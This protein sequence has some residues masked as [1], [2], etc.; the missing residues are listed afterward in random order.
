MTSRGSILIGL[1]LCTALLAVTRLAPAPG[2][3]GECEAIEIETNE[4]GYQSGYHVFAERDVIYTWF[5]GEAGLV[6]ESDS[7]QRAEFAPHS[8]D[9][10]KCILEAP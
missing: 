9:T 7:G 10:F 8:V 1:L 2:D 4:T 5:A 6:V 3:G